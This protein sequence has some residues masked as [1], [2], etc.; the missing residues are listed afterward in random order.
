MGRPGTI[1]FSAR[2]VPCDHVLCQEVKGELILLSLAGERYYRLNKMGSRMWHELTAAE[3]IE[4]A[5]RNLLESY[6]VDP[7]QLRDD[8]EVFLAKLIGCDLVRLTS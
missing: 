2:V 5:C 1:A 6:Q 3:S 4:A 7:Q 8:L